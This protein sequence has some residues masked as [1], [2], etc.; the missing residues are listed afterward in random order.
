MRRLIYLI[1][2]IAIFATA[3][4]GSDAEVASRN[5]SQAADQ[6]EVQRRVV[7]INGITDQY[8]LSIEG[9]CSIEADTL[10]VQLKVTCKRGEN[11]FVKH[12][13]GLS[14]NV[15]YMVEQL[16]GIDVSTQ[17]YQVIFKPESI[18]PNVDIEP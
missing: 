12:F 3:C 11:D 9:L 17:R 13:L 1:A 8:L 5:L 10:D 15:T 14:D 7:F 16:V 18:I 6:F 2:T 4:S